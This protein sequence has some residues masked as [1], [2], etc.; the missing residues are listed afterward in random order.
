MNIHDL[1]AAEGRYHN[2]FKQEFYS[3]SPTN[4]ETPGQPKNL[5]HNE[6][7]NSVCKW[8]DVEAEIHTLSEV[9]KKNA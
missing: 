9:Y 2:K 7:F 3:G 1:L 8:L 6:N 5:T 4:T